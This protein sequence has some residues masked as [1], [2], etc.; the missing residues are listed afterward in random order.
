MPT[1]T[2][3]YKQAVG[4]QEVMEVDGPLA[5]GVFLTDGVVNLAL[6]H[7]DRSGTS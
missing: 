7:G 1:R 3:F 6:L 4:L 5:E 2:E